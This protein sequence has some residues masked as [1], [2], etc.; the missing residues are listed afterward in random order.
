MS[1]KERISLQLDHFTAS[2]LDEIA[3]FVAYIKFRSKA[4]KTQIP[5][6]DELAALYCQAADEDVELAET[7]MS[8]YAKCLAAED[9]K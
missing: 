6:Q 9:M 2:E 8:D 3:K 4:Q 1:V 7:G 5:S